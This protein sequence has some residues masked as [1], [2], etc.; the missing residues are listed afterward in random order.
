MP[1]R[2]SAS[3][4]K[5]ASSASDNFLNYLA[6]SEI[7]IPMRSRSRASGRWSED[8]GDDPAERHATESIR[9]KTNGGVTF[10]LLQGKILGLVREQPRI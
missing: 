9:K 6:I 1:L 3:L 5:S 8:E 7:R 10:L 2:S 4:P